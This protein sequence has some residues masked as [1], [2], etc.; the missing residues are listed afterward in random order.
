[1]Q[2]RRYN[3]LPL[4]YG[5]YLN[6]YAF[7]APKKAATKAFKVFSKVRK[8]KV[9]PQQA[10]YLNKAKHAIEYIV[11]HAV[12]VYRWP[13]PKATV[14]LVHGWESNSF[15]WRH[16]IEK[17]KAAEFN[18]IAF[19]APSHGY[20]SGTFL[21]VPLY[22]AVLNHIVTTYHAKH[23][24]GHSV[25]GTTVMY[26][27]FKNPNPQ[28]EKL[29]TLAAPSELH[30]IMTHFQNLLRF[31]T[32]VMRALDAYVLNQFGFR[33]R[34]FSV[35]R[36]AQS[37]TKKGLLFHDTLDPIT[38]YRASAQVHAHW[39]G[40]SVVSTE[41]LGHSMRHDEVNDQIIRFLHA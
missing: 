36:F 26:N 28:I 24:I 12:Q 4:V 25:G 30:E 16:L 29:I 15:R 14:V 19:D 11:G 27:T 3:I 7:F 17:L 40:S 9:T 13:G 2:K 39:K 35:A 5:K 33:I 23:L 8:G 22:E 18:I 37:N 32:R 34:E 31:N 10:E 6:L 38:P 41:G 21:H 20:S 1:M